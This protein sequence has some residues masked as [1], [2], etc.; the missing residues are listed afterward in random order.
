MIYC[1]VFI[2]AGSKGF[3]FL[4]KTQ[5]KIKNTIT[6]VSTIAITGNNR[7]S[8]VLMTDTVSSPVETSGLAIPPVDTVEAP[9]RT[10][11]AP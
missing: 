6:A 10:T 8:I 9:R 1:S 4:F 5:R 11:L 7:E 3:D 2:I